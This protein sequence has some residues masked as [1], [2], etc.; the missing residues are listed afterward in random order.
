[1]SNRPKD[2]KN[3]RNKNV[4]CHRRRPAAAKHDFC[5]KPNIMQAITARMCMVLTRKAV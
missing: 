1:M 2:P 5:A 3:A 4:L